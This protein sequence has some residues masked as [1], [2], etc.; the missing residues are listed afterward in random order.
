[1]TSHT[2]GPNMLAQVPCLARSPQSHTVVMPINS[3]TRAPKPSMKLVSPS[4]KANGTATWP[5]ASTSNACSR[6]SFMTLPKGH[7]TF[8]CSHYPKRSLN[9]R[10]WG[11]AR[12]LPMLTYH[13]VDCDTTGA[14]SLG[15]VRMHTMSSSGLGIRILMAFA[16]LHGPCRL[17]RTSTSSLRRLT[18]STQ[19]T[20][21]LFTAPG[22]SSCN[23]LR[24]G[25]DPTAPVPV[26]LSSAHY[27]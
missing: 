1:L 14:A 16:R 5:P 25:F 21:P 26:P 22:M 4:W 2:D 15:G 6:S 10:T 7:K 19:Y 13:S 17:L 27:A 18:L 3:R 8:L 12:L 20:P 11:N 9:D 24:R 23:C